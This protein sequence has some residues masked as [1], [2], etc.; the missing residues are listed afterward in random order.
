MNCALP[1]DHLKSRIIRV[2]IGFRSIHMGSDF[3]DCMAV[4]S[5]ILLENV[6]PKTV[7]LN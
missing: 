1:F 4:I 6:D 2:S 3:E 5:T 7:C